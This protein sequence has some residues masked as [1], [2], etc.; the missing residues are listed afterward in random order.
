MARGASKH[1][2]DEYVGGL[3]EACTHRTAPGC[4]CT[5]HT[6][7]VT[8]DALDVPENDPEQVRM[9]KEIAGMAA[10]AGFIPTFTCA[11]YL[12]GDCS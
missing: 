7:F 12:V 11:P 4:Y 8:F 5:I 9:Q 10:D 6:A 1:T 2:I 3:R